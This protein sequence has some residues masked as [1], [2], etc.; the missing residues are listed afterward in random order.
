MNSFFSMCSLSGMAFDGSRMAARRA[1]L[2]MTQ[3]DLAKAIGVSQQAITQWENGETRRP[4]KLMELSKTLGVDPAWLLGAG[5]DAEGERPSEFIYVD[6]YDFKP[7]MGGGG[8][9]PDYNEPAFRMPLSPEYAR[10]A[11]LNTKHLI[12]VE[13]EGDSMAP[14]LLS[15]D[16]ILIDTSDKNPARGGIFAVTINETIVVKRLEIVI[17]ADVPTLKLISSNPEHSP[18]EALVEETNIVGRVVWFARRM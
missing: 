7:G 13:T 12:S 5:N 18:Y 11:R 17:G 9:V 14:H 8:I 6:A 15:G 3:G 16:Q 1:E 4:K 2:G 10:K